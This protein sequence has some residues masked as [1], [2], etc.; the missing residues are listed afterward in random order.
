MRFESTLR[1]TNNNPA[2]L[3]AKLSGNK[4]KV[5]AFL[6]LLV[7]G[8]LVLISLNHFLPPVFL[9]FLQTG[10]FF[11]LGYLHFLILRA[12]VTGLT[13]SEKFLYSSL[14]ATVVFLAGSIFYFIAPLVF[15]WQTVVAGV[16]AFL[17][18]FVLAEAWRLFYFMSSQAAAT[19]RYSADVSLQKATT[20][21]NSMPV[22]FKIQAGQLAG[23]Y[24]V[25]FRAPV[26]MKLGTIFYHMVQEQNSQGENVVRL[27]SG[28]GQPYEWAFSITVFGWKT[29]LDPELSLLE[30][31]LKENAIVTAQRISEQNAL[32]IAAMEND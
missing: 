13:P 1:S 8:S 7:L 18:P 31:G 15:S 2:T 17:L 23:E 4:K 30:N 22:R 28:E 10:G 27:S 21:L 24:T 19:W 16:C 26:R 6:L 9:I 20:F 29:F 12:N 14:L 32:E 11:C 25:G 5:W 3:F